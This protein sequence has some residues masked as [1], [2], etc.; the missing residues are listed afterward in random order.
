[1]ISAASLY[2]AYCHPSRGDAMPLVMI[3][4]IYV[5]APFAIAFG[6][7]TDAMV[8]DTSA[9]HVRELVVK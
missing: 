3:A 6:A 4:I 5:I 9:P 2:R 1:M 7:F 8:V